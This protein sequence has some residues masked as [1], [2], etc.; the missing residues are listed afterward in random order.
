M[1]IVWRSVECVGHGMF[2]RATN[3]N[4]NVC[5]ASN[6]HSFVPLQLLIKRVIISYFL[7]QVSTISDSLVQQ[8][9]TLSCNNFQ[10]SRATTSNSLVQQF[11]TLSCNKLNN[12][13]MHTTITLGFHSL[14]AI[15]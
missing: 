14:S 10:L 11:P 8:L 5:R 3:A 12:A 7:V 1:L 15:C 9:P 2:R 13:F 4:V 6:A